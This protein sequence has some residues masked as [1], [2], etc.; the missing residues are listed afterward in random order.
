MS[1]PQ[2]HGLE[3]RDQKPDTSWSVLGKSSLGMVLF[4]FS[5]SSAS[6]K[7]VAA[8]ICCVIK[9]LTVAL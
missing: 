9:P 2:L 3:G 8:V 1:L 7:H 4:S 5:M 6:S